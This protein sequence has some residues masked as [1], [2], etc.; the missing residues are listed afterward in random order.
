[1]DEDDRRPLFEGVTVAIIPDERIE[2]D[3]DAILSAIETNGGKYVPLRVPDQQID[4]IA[5]ISH[6]ISNHIDFPQ[7]NEAIERGI[8]IVKPSW[9]EQSLKRSKLAGPR[10]HSP[11]PSQYFQDVVVSFAEI[12]EGD[13]DAIVAGVLALGGQYS[14]PL[15]RFVTH[16]VTLDMGHNKCSIAQD[17]VRTCKIVLPH[18][19]DVCLKLGKL[20]REEPYMFPDPPLLRF[21]SSKP[22]NSESPHIQ[23]AITAIPSGTP[24]KTALDSPPPSPSNARKNLNAFMGRKIK[25]SE[26]LELSS[27]MTETLDSLINHGG[28]VLTNNIHEADLYIGKY[29]DGSD[30]V[31]AARAGKEVANLSWLYHVINRN[32]YTNP[33]SKLLHYPV[34]R[35]GIPGFENMRI[36]ISNYNGDARVYLENL[37]THCGAQFTKTMKQDNTHLITAHTHSEKCEAAQEWNINMI[38]HLWIEES[39]AKCAVQSLTNPRYTTFPSQS[40]LGEVCGQTMLDM[41]KVEQIYYPKRR[42][43]PHNS[44]RASKAKALDILHHQ[45]D[46]IALYQREMKR[47]GGVTHGVRRSSRAEDFSDHSDGETQYQPSKTTKKPKHHALES[48][49]LLPIKYRMMV[50]G[51]DRWLGKP[52]DEDVAKFQLRKLGIQLTQNVGEVDILVAPKIL[53]TRK[54]VAALASAPLVVHTKYLDTALKQGKLMEIPPILQDRDTEERLGFRLK[55]ALERARL[56]QHQLFRGWPIFVT[57]DAPGGYDTFRE[58]IELNGGD[59]YLY[60]GRTGLTLPK[61]L[62][63]QDATATREGQSQGDEDS[64]DHVYLVSGTSEA[65]VKLW[66]AFHSLAERQAVKARIVKTDWLLNAAMSQRVVW[67]E[68]WMLSEELLVSQRDR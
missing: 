42:A 57:K 50:T 14:S 12:P 22:S 5:T 8:S 62:K 6:I 48:P 52:K 28:G 38:N 65:E 51:D 2:A 46:D 54:F 29:R 24:S 34:P 4:K 16:L 61:P 37:I 36:S 43:S 33:V 40:H 19:F 41:T 53:R 7:Y 60:Q 44:G 31:T 27:H 64:S 63:R 23:G 32:K 18:W 59:V 35:N 15:T 3:F 13:K 25:L 58:I 21:A 17:K 30:Y 49:E 1:M 10:Q 39:Y 66:K 68:K 26:D 47:K 67:D 20:I 56:N 45:A 9:V 55:D 11:D